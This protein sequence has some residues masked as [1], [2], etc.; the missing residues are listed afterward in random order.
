M[1]DPVDKIG[2]LDFRN[3]TTWPL[4]EQGRNQAKEV[5]EQ[6]EGTGFMALKEWQKQTKESQA[7]YDGSFLKYLR[8]FLP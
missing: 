5:L 2:L 4:Q 1:E 8:A 7:D 6:G 3:V